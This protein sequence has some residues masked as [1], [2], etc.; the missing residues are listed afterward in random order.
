MLTEEKKVRLRQLI[1]EAED[2]GESP[3][4]IQNELIPAYKI[5][6][7]VP[8]P[9]KQPEVKQEKPEA[10]QTEKYGVAGAL[11][12][13]TTESTERGGG[14]VPRM[15]AGAGDAL[16]LPAR[17]VSAVATGAG[18]LAGGGS[19]STAAKEAANDLSRTKSTEGGAFGFIQDM[20]LDPTSS[21]LLAG[22]GVAARAIK[23]APTIGKAL[24][25]TAASGAA[26]GAGSGAYQQSKGGEVSAPQTIGQAILGAGI[27]AGS[28]GLGKAVQSGAGKLL[29]NTAIRNIDISLRPGQY[30]RKIGYDHENVVKHDLI[31]SPRETYE[32]SVEKLNTLQTRAKEIAGE[33]DAT[34]DIDKIFEDVKSGLDPKNNPEEFARQIA[35]I[36][37][38]K[39]SYIEAFGYVVDAPTAM[40]IRTKIG[41]KSA[42]VGRTSGGAKIDPDADWKEDVYNA[43]YLKMKNDLHENLGG[44]LK[45]INKAQSEIIPVKQVAERRMPIS[46]SNQRVGLSDLLTTGIGQSAAGAVL[47]AGA[48]AGYG[49]AS[50]ENGFENAV[51]GLTIGAALAGGRRA[52]GSPAATKA[53]YKLGGKLNPETK[54]IPGYKKY[55]QPNKPAS[56][57]DDSD[58]FEKSLLTPKQYKEK[59]DAEKLQAIQGEEIPDYNPDDLLTPEAYAARRHLEEMDKAY[60]GKD[61]RLQVRDESN[62]VK[63]AM[64]KSLNLTNYREIKMENLS[65]KKQAEINKYAADITN[66][67]M[68][69]ERFRDAGLIDANTDKVH[70]DDV[71]KWMNEASKER[72]TIG[73]SLSPKKPGILGM[74]GNERGA[75]GSIT[76]G[77]TY[78]G[79]RDLGS[80]GVL[81]FGNYGKV[82]SGQDAGAIFVTPSKKYAEG[83]VKTDGGALY[84]ADVDYAKENIFDAT[85]KEDLRK[86]EKL[87]GPQGIKS[88]TET[89]S[90]GAA[91]WATLSQFTEEIESAGFTGAKFLERAGENIEPMANGSFKV[92]GKPVYSY[93]FFHEI[94]VTRV[95][96]PQS[97]GSALKNERGSVGSNPQI[98]TESFKNWFGDWK[99]EPAKASKVVDENGEP[100]RLYHSTYDTFTKFDRK[101]LGS[102]TKTNTDSKSAHNLSELGFWHSDKDVNTGNQTM[103]NFVQLKNPK[104]FESLTGDAW[105]EAATFKSGKDWM[106]SLKEGGYDGIIVKNDD[107]FGGTSYVV[108]SPNQIKSAT[109]NSG[110]FSKSINDI[111]GSSALKT[112]AATGATAAGALTIG[113]AL[114]AKKKK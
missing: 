1:Q 18:T 13:A 64:R 35:L 94:P 16:T 110:K 90:H 81:S 47:G 14:F 25:K 67:P 87:I 111:R 38:A 20:A 65:P 29:K 22:T 63:Q 26:Y 31:G 4:V 91:D 60:G 54:V 66:E 53:F 52:L 101:K 40:K 46:E 36:D 74:L 112:M 56:K 39:K 72:K 49:A 80:R 11:F 86:I 109:G 19:L 114:K 32:K 62:S 71:I 89:I 58:P 41:E 102:L 57:I 68:M 45:E 30:G 9:V 8:E 88:I 21:P 23:A 106:K 69:R 107:E 28:T 100:K 113:E 43:L 97:I 51:K 2:N 84:K 33:S 37:E 93:G 10:T 7:D 76:D 104:E 103:S 44:E 17:A 77:V 96:K 82:G 99:K 5:K 34:F 105:D 95:E 42:F 3:D 83:Y 6:Y 79:G 55:E 108:F 24:A 92:T 70:P 61:S 85:N 73:E 15:I 50:G 98:H 12:P 75:V 59:Q 78:H 48:G 27:G